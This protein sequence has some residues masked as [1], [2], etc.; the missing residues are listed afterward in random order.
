MDEAVKERFKWKFFGLAAILNLIVLLLA[1]GVIAYL[2]VPA[3]PGIAILLIAAAVVLIIVFMKRYR[4]TKAWL[5]DHAGE[6]NT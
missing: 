1:G 5:D 3:S 4:R 6:K 2:F